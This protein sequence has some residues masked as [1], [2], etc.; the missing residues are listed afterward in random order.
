MN[1]RIDDAQG[2][3][4]AAFHR[5]FETEVIRLPAR[6]INAASPD[7]AL[8]HEKEDGAFRYL[9]DLTGTV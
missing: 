6:L 2:R 7:L 5:H 8:V 4:P 9:W 3:S 1:P